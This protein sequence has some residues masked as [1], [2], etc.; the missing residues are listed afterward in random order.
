M[1]R[2]VYL[3]RATPDDVVALAALQAVCFSHPW[4]RTQI[5]AEIAAGPPGAVLVLRSPVARGRPAEPCAACAYR[6]VLDELHLLDVAVA[7]DRRRRGLARFLM[8]VA[9]RRAL[10]AGA[11]T[12][13]LEVRA[14]NHEALALYASLGF[15][16]QG[17]R[18]HYYRD[19]V[20]D[21]L[22]LQRRL[23]SSDC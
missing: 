9:M 10:R 23:V 8:R 2:A 20:E 3:D 21:A 16:R 4:T 1:T 22:L 12:A 11:L 5:A 14:G 13:L 18:R 17:A 19:P 15:E 6:I 7:P